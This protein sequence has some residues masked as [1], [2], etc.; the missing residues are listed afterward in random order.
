MTILDT[1]GYHLFEVVF[2]SCCKDDHWKQLFRQGLYPATHRNP[3]T[4]FAVNALEHFHSLN[5]QGKTSA[6]DYYLSALQ[7]T[8]YTIVWSK[9]QVSSL[10]LIKWYSLIEL[11]DAS[12]NGG[13]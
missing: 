12:V 5:R 13:G 4:A 8:D 1:N 10:R 2:C 9:K 7:Q 3:R 6:Y 11:R